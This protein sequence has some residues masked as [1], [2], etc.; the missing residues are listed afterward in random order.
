MRR[1][2][3][4]SAPSAGPPAASGPGSQPP[5]RGKRPVDE[6]SVRATKGTIEQP[7]P[8]PR[9][10]LE[11]QLQP[12]PR[13]DNLTAPQTTAWRPKSPSYLT[14]KNPYGRILDN[15]E[16]PYR[17]RGKPAPGPP[18]QL[19]SNMGGRRR[20]SGSFEFVTRPTPPPAP[21]RKV[22]VDGPPT[23]PPLPP[24]RPPRKMFS[25][26]D[27]K[28]FFERKTLESRKDPLFPSA[29]SAA[30]AKGASA[31]SRIKQQPPKVGSVMRAT[32]GN[33]EAHPAKESSARREVSNA[34]LP[35]SRPP[36]K[37]AERRQSIHR[38]D[39]FTR[40]KA[41]DVKPKVLV[42]TTSRISTG[43]RPARRRNSPWRSTEV[44]ERSTSESMHAAETSVSER[45]RSTNVFTQ[46]KT[47]A[48]PPRGVQRSVVQRDQLNDFS[49]APRTVSINSEQPPASDE[50]VRRHSI[51]KSSTAE[52]YKASPSSDPKQAEQTYRS[53]TSNPVR[54]LAGQ[55]DRGA[56]TGDE[57]IISRR[58]LL[59]ERQ[60]N[61][62]RR[63]RQ[64][65]RS[66]LKDQESDA[67]ES[68]QR[69]RRRSTMSEPEDVDVNF[70]THVHNFGEPQPTTEKLEE[71]AAK[72]LSHDGS[73]SSHSLTRRTSTQAVNTSADVGVEEGYYSIEVPEHVD[74]RGGYGRRKT[75]DF[76]FPGARLKSRATFRAFKA[77]LQNPSNWIKRACGH[78]STVSAIE[79]REEAA[80]MPCSQC[81]AMPP[82]MPM[83]SKHHRSRRRVAT[84]SSAGS[85][86][87]SPRGNRCRRQHHS[88][89]I[90]R[91]K[92]GDTFAQDLGYI[93]DS[94]LEEHQSTL[95][96]VINNM[97]F[98]QPNLVQ[99]RK[100]SAD[101]VKR[102]EKLNV[103]APGQLG[104]NMN[105]ALPSLR[106]SVKSAPELI[107]LVK[108]V[109]DD[110]GVDLDQ[111]YTPKDDAKFEAAPIERSPERSPVSRH[112]SALEPVVEKL[113]EE[114]F[115]APVIRKATGIE[116]EETQETEDAWLQKTRRQ[117]TQLSKTRS[118][119]MDEL[120]I[121]ADDLGVHLDER[122][123]SSTYIDPVERSL[124][125]KHTGIWRKSTRL[126]NKS[127]DSV[128]DDIPRMIDQEINDR[129]L[130]R[131][132]TRISTQS[133]RMSMISQGMLKVEVIPP[134]EIQ[135]WL[136]CAQTE[137]PAA[138]DSIT[139]VMETLPAVDFAPGLETEEVEG[140]DEGDE[141]ER[142]EDAEGQ[143]DQS[144][145]AAAPAT[146]RQTDYAVEPEEQPQYSPPEPERKMVE[147][148]EEQPESPSS[149]A[150][151]LDAD[152]VKGVIQLEEQPDSEVD[153]V[154]ELGTLE[155]ELQDVDFQSPVVRKVTTRRPTEKTPSREAQSVEADLRPPVVHKM[156][157]WRSTE[158]ILRT[159]LELEA[160]DL[161]PPVVRKVTTGHQMEPEVED[162][163]FR[164]P[165]VR[166]VATRR[167]TER[168]P[169]PGPEIKDD[170]FQPPVVRKITTRR[171][172]EQ[173]APE[174]EDE[175]Q[176]PLMRKVKTRWPTEQI[177]LEEEEGEDFQPPVVRK[178]TTRRETEPVIPEPEDADFQPPIVH[179]I[180][181][182]RSNERVIPEPEFDDF[183]PVVVRKVTTS[184]QIE[185]N[186]PELEDE[187]DFE[188]PL[189]RKVTTRRPTEQFVPGPEEDDFHRPVRKTTTRIPTELDPVIRR[190]TTTR[191]PTQRERTL[192]VVQDPVPQVLSRTATEVIGLGASRSSPIQSHR[193][194]PEE[195]GMLRRQTATEAV[196]EPKM[197][198]RRG[199]TTRTTTGLTDLTMNSIDPLDFAS[200]EQAQDRPASR[201]PTM[202]R[203]PTTEFTPPVMRAAV[204]FPTPTR[205][206]T[207]A[208]TRAP[209]RQPTLPSRRSTLGP[210]ITSQEASPEVHPLERIAREP[211]ALAREP[212]MNPPP[213]SPEASPVISP[214]EVTAREPT[215][216]S[217][218]STTVPPR[219]SPEESPEIHPLERLVREP[220]LLSV[221]STMEPRPSSPEETPKATPIER[222]TRKPSTLSR[223]PTELP[224]LPDSLSPSPPAT[225]EAGPE[226]TEASSRK[227]TRKHTI[228]SRQSTGLSCSEESLEAEQTPPISRKV[229][230]ERTHI[231][232]QPTEVSRVIDS[233]DAE[234]TPSVSRKVTR[235]L[236]RVSRQP[237]QQTQLSETLIPDHI[238]PV[239]R[240]VIR[241]PTRIFRQPTAPEEVPLMP[242][243]QTTAQSRR[244]TARDESPSSTM[245]VTRMAR[246]D[247]R[248]PAESN[249]NPSK[250]SESET[251]L[252]I[253][254]PPSTQASAQVL[255]KLIRAPSVLISRRTTST[256]VEAESDFNPSEPDEP[257]IPAVPSRT[258]SS[259]VSKKLTRAPTVPVSRRPTSNLP[260]K[261]PSFTMPVM[262]MAR[263]DTEKEA[264]REFDP[265][266][267]DESEPFVPP[268]RKASA[269]V[270]R[271]PTTVLIASVS[272]KST[273]APTA[274]V[275]RKPTKVPTSS[276]PR[277]PTSTLG[278][279]EPSPSMPVVLMAWE[280]P[281][282]DEG[283]DFH[284]EASD[285]E[286]D[287]P[288]RKLSTQIL[289]APTSALNSS[290]LSGAATIPI[291]RKPTAITRDGS[292]TSNMP[293][294]RIARAGTDHKDDD[295]LNPG[296]PE[297][298]VF[299]P[300]R[301]TPL[302]LSRKPTKAAPF[303]LERGDTGTMQRQ[304]TS[305]TYDPVIRRTPK[306]Q[307]A[308]LQEDV[309]EDYMS[310]PVPARSESRRESMLILRESTGIATVPLERK[311]TEVLER[312][313]SMSLGDLATEETLAQQP[314]EVEEKAIRVPTHRESSEDEEEVPIP[315][316]ATKVRRATEKVTLPPVDLTVK[317]AVLHQPS[318]LERKVPRKPTE[319]VTPEEDEPIPRRASTGFSRQGTYEDPFQ[320][321]RMAARVPTERAPLE[322]EKPVQRSVTGISRQGTAD[323]PPTGLIQ[324][325]LEL[326]TEADR[327]FSPSTQ[328]SVLDEPLAVLY[329]YHGSPAP[330]IPDP[331]KEPSRAPTRKETIRSRRRSTVEDIPPD[332]KTVRIQDDPTASYSP[333]G[334]YSRQRR[335]AAPEQAPTAPVIV[336][337]IVPNETLAAPVTRI[338]EPPTLP[339]EEI[340]DQEPSRLDRPP[341]A[342]LSRDPQSL[343]PPLEHVTT[344]ALERR[345]STIPR[346]LTV[347]TEK[348]RKPSSAAPGIVALPTQ[349]APKKTLPA[350]R[351]RKARKSVYGVNLPPDQQRPPAPE[352]PVRDTPTWTRPDTQTPPPK[353]KEQPAPKPK[354]GFFGFGRTGNQSGPFDPRHQD[355]HQDILGERYK[356]QEVM[357]PHPHDSPSSSQ[358]KLIHP[359][360]STPLLEEISTRNPLQSQLDMMATNPVLQPPLDETTIPDLQQ[361]G[362]SP[363]QLTGSLVPY[364]ITPLATKLVRDPF[365]AKRRNPFAINLKR[366]KTFVTKR[367][368]FLSMKRL[369]LFVGR[370]LTNNP[371]ARRQFR[372]RQLSQDLSAATPKTA[373]K[374][375]TRRNVVAQGAE[376]QGCGI[377]KFLQRKGRKEKVQK[378]DVGAQ[379]SGVL[380][381]RKQKRARKKILDLPPPSLVPEMTTVILD[382]TTSQT[383]PV[384]RVV[385]PPSIELIQSELSAS[386]P[387]SPARAPSQPSMQQEEYL[388]QV[389]PSG[390][391]PIA[392]SSSRSPQLRQQ[393][394]SQ[395]RDTASN[396]TKVQM[397]RTRDRAPQRR[398]RE[399]LGWAHYGR[400]QKG[401]QSR[402]QRGSSLERQVMEIRLEKHPRS[403]RRRA[404]RREIPVDVHQ[405]RTA[406]DLQELHG[407]RKTGVQEG[408]AVQLDLMTSQDSSVVQP[409]LRQDRAAH[410]VRLRRRRSPPNY[411]R[412]TEVSSRPFRES[413]QYQRQ[414]RKPH[415]RL[416]RVRG[417][418]TLGRDWDVNNSN[419]QSQRQRQRQYSSIEDQESSRERPPDQRYREV[420]HQSQTSSYPY[421][422]QQQRMI[423]DYSPQ[424]SSVLTPSEEI[425]SSQRA[426]PQRLYPRQDRRAFGDEEI[427]W[428]RQNGMGRM[429]EGR[430][431][432]EE[433]MLERGQLVELDR[434]G[435]MVEASR[436]DFERRRGLEQR[437]WGAKE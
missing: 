290:P 197:P 126:R 345:R 229:T 156:T 167:P 206:P 210:Q 425:P 175:F 393:E 338:A 232:R 25:V 283:S 375:T 337:E 192:L 21:E 344:T 289:K 123:R 113:E 59:P 52:S 368:P 364:S 2:T 384:K 125:K 431:R 55:L 231:S 27:A 401:A 177:V 159:E 247:P 243:R 198:S 208:P 284:H 295:N 363:L 397:Q 426:R 92:C 385:D 153:V 205:A 7:Q 64:G 163:E 149:L 18:S 227:L 235:E 404:E 8:P 23:P 164:H 115:E 325:N 262:R 60:P 98:S 204:T 428:S 157:T 5:A 305:S 372:K 193:V 162:D 91:D 202:E 119:L 402:L 369:H 249:F 278:E 132:L 77:P 342:D 199:T 39:P 294:R 84:D 254:A 317:R 194:T 110:L 302:Y 241:E 347:P 409:S 242:S 236:I 218:T 395:Q 318:E 80:K 268:S 82:P 19:G 106:E 57:E 406:Y 42:R 323:R 336:A 346:V 43:E 365:V 279:E 403:E 419:Y 339:T 225:V 44:A 122:R 400:S 274:P 291:S 54:R 133:R 51:R 373:R 366:N 220:A 316:R 234:V 168:V 47:Q 230:R 166:K 411:S 61:T 211:T 349:F 429:Q 334:L 309:S 89:C 282:I 246:A 104:P 172:T 121:I 266:G 169:T 357:K 131:V 245:A 413:E 97:K 67:N 114:D 35:I 343:A 319:E 288:S 185:P 270:S 129:R 213:P 269:Q 140:T 85:S 348:Q 50:T 10:T 264:K 155:P 94:I 179:K 352:Y 31:I 214:A 383:G 24:A 233:L 36:T 379:P 358:E 300:S 181:T 49:E 81:R 136:E 41:D 340:P 152:E 292:P 433:E 150:S 386:E 228:I 223:M 201:K 380:K 416:T 29:G 281:E 422:K 381:R 22:S 180:T 224:P 280:E 361:P 333:P 9:R 320:V 257:E 146:Q 143:S 350:G 418:E 215:V 391:T 396:D 108:S 138:I 310:E 322:E 112:S 26:K 93:I 267:P 189:A 314:T 117:L 86:Q 34:A 353:P 355:T 33:Q 376:L 195:T 226:P 32:D 186:V 398:E 421:Q 371:L 63:W 351:K 415:D 207:H 147:Y 103:G 427:S 239:S 170:G 99:L 190:T 87:S 273:G 251:E 272:R 367:R 141:Y 286:V 145:Y 238:P 313:K 139:A 293:V 219:S 196:D 335:I 296:I 191:R 332:E 111:K 408:Q 423:H 222:N 435:R 328:S 244:P 298:D 285:P 259:Q 248:P 188:P 327:S 306:N 69:S 46:A 209:T 321:E 12:L 161:Q 178:V 258:A 370:R 359:S 165:V 399:P 301:R 256:E 410:S 436:R 40:A 378:S 45:S 216:L 78:F 151:E 142:S 394:Q 212:T 120:D 56:A 276:V 308:E 392:R 73:T 324:R 74:W 83:T 184:R 134:E 382:A 362:M 96:N 221:K 287:P 407:I 14:G 187:P 17:E 71:I 38:A 16:H 354:R 4:L 275:A 68:V 390:P 299:F 240:K 3:G 182:R 271:N 130:S 389:L 76:G 341:T 311:L 417:R 315:R 79:P 66:A 176:P 263:V 70:E 217:R 250:A 356:G 260:E 37:V 330:S 62:R 414:Q 48:Q 118:Q 6:P 11:S 261:D 265:S 72:N 174:P 160:K 173:V 28:T 360:P 124:S 158:Q 387:L 412:G 107:E 15:V 388:Q 331:P 304:R 374:G 20:T 13:P 95:Q 277:K 102:S 154:A 377:R 88:E 65:S 303:P 135:E 252:V 1:G 405:Q 128:F 434:Q 329:V 430:K 253:T 312:Q 307:P 100:V 144:E 326:E 171:S 109:A 432:N 297:P 116:S 200:T 137:L 183:E 255:R 148:R 127:V 58:Y 420:A 424:R 105:D 237:T 75:Q 30:I 203:A 90:S 437:L 53:Q 101:L